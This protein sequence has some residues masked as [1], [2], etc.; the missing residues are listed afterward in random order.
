MDANTAEA[1]W[2]TERGVTEIMLPARCSGLAAPFLPSTLHLSLTTVILS[3]LRAPALIP[4]I[5]F[6]AFLGTV[7]PD[8]FE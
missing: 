4:L 2:D 8:T 3:G 7:K 6:R 1:T 5:Y